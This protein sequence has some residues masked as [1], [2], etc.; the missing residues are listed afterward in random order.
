MSDITHPE[1]DTLVAVPTGPKRRTCLCLRCT[2]MIPVSKR[3]C[4]AHWTMMPEF[5]KTEMFDWY[6]GNDEAFEI[7]MWK[8]VLAISCLEGI[9]SLDYMIPPYAKAAWVVDDRC[10]FYDNLARISTV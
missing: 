10:R 1:G 7:S 4:L 9:P 3:F 6:D 2:E 5:L 8:G